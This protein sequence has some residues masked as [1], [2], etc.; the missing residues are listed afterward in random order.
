MNLDQEALNIAMDQGGVIKD[1][2]CQKNTKL[3]HSEF[4]QNYLTGETQVDITGDSES[5]S[6]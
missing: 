1:F 3:Y 4:S 6:E 5:H 2:I